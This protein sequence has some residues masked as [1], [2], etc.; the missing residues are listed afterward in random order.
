MKPIT[1]ATLPDATAQ[2]VFDWVVSNLL[3]Q[4]KKSLDDRECCRYRGN[5]GLKC[6]AGWCISDDE[7]AVV[8]NRFENV[9]WGAWG[10]ETLRLLPHPDLAHNKLIRDMQRAHDDNPVTSWHSIFKQLAE[11]HGLDPSVM[12]KL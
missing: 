12:G 6:A 5:D 1:L 4:G 7:Y 11:E 8:G 2:E 3:R 9:V 10:R